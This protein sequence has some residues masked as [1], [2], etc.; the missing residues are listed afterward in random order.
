VL[1]GSSLPT[2]E[3]EWSSPPRYRRGLRTV[4]PTGTLRWRRAKPQSVQI[5]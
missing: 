3:A 5:V 4:F 1:D 2:R